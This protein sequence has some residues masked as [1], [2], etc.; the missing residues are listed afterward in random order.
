V[1]L[2]PAVAAPADPADPA[3]T[4]VEATPRGAGLRRA[5]DGMFGVI[6]PSSGPSYDQE[7]SAAGVD[8]A[9]FQNAIARWLADVA[10]SNYGR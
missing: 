4:D 1:R 5:N 10:E 6:D 7:S 2:T 3:Y 8:D 9:I